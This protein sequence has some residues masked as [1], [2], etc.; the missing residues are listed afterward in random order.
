MNSESNTKSI[1]HPDVG[2]DLLKTYL[3]YGLSV[4]S[5]IDLKKDRTSADHF[6]L[7]IQKNRFIPK[8]KNPKTKSMTRIWEKK[9]GGWHLIYRDHSGGETIFE[10]NL[11]GSKISI[12]QTNRDWNQAVFVLLNPAMAAT[13]YLQ[14]KTVL[15]ASSL[16]LD[17]CSYLFL[18]PS[19]MGKSTISA[20]LALNGFQL[21]A[22]DMAVTDVH[23]DV[24]VVQSG[25][26][27]LKLFNHTARELD[28]TETQLKMIFPDTPD[29]PES[30]IHAD[31]FGTDFFDGPAALKNIYILSGREKGANRFRTEK[32][33]SGKA[34]ISLLHYLYGDNWLQWPPEEKLKFCIQIASKTSVYKLWVP[35]GIKPLLKAAK[36]F[37]HDVWNQS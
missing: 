32:I 12:S 27:L 19:G 36:V 25:Y 26:P 33:T 9:E 29:Y 24:P 35:E 8:V 13:L 2:S 22:D 16:V 10:Y 7:Y 21:H 1:H 37:R 31:Q 34:V 28:L 23:S 6:D 11:D 4:A 14:K 5:E 20:A 18:G 30:W 15:H 17:G 3:L